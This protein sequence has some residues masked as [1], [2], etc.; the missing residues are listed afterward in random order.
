MLPEAWVGL[1]EE[2]IEEN[3]K[4]YQNSQTDIQGETLLLN[5]YMQ[6]WCPLQEFITHWNCKTYKG[7]F[8]ERMAWNLSPVQ[9]CQN[10][11]HETLSGFFENI[12]RLSPFEI[13]QAIKSQWNLLE[14]LFR[15]EGRCFHLQIYSLRWLWGSTITGGNQEHFAISRHYLLIKVLVM[16]F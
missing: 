16:L 4:Y 6:I 15:K 9:F 1:N 13:F 2:E 7:V 8:L 11:I 12:N 14:G 3:E 5:Y 10:S